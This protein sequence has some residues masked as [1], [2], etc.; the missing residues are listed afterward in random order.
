MHLIVEEEK[1]QLID[2]QALIKERTKGLEPYRD[3]PEF[4]K[5]ND[6]LKN[7][8]ERI[9]RNLCSTKQNLNKI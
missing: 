9:Q 6:L 7:E 4:G 1:I 5:Y 8:S 3:R 2:L